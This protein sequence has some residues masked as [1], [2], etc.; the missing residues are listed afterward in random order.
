M[1]SPR[2]LLLLLPLAAALALTACDDGPTTTQARDV[3][4]FTR[5][6]NRDS[7]DVRLQVG[8][9]QRVRV[10]AGEKVIDDI[11]TEV[12]DGTLE[13]TFDR[14]GFGGGDVEVE[15][16]VPEL[17]AIEASGS[18]DIEAAGVDAD[19]FEVVSDGSADLVVAGT[20]TRLVVDLDGSGEA[21]LAE[22]AAD[23][24]QVTVDGS[25]DLDLRADERLDVVVDGSGDVRYHGDPTV[26][27]HVDGSGD[28][29]RAG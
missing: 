4:D 13:I 8:E 21:D 23:E 2:R 19:A 28:L 5:I 29:S 1:P 17:T 18:G 11:R 16:S 10:R 20:A 6:D 26:T 7:V 9:P 25:G 27:R 24:A 14:D 12:R 15:V 22:L 3:A